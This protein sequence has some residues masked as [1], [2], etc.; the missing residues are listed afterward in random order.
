MCNNKTINYLMIN[1]LFYIII[2]FIPHTTMYLLGDKEVRDKIYY[3]NFGFNK[4]I[5]YE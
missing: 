5:K 3:C 4:F 1:V 2:P